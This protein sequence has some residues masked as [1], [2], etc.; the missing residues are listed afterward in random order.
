M[1]ELPKYRY[2][3]VPVASPV[4]IG[5][6]GIRV[7]KIALLGGSAASKCEL[8]NTTDGSGTAQFTINALTNDY[9][10]ESFV[11]VGGL[12]FPVACYVKPTGTVCIAHIWFE[13][14]Q[15]QVAFA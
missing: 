8:F 13:P 3:V 5:S 10:S 1:A 6:G 12:A 14:M 15:N 11:E 7:L 9:K 2:Q 4:Q